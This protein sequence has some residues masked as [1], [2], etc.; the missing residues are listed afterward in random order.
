MCIR[1]ALN[2]TLSLLLA[3][4][5]CTGM[6]EEFVVTFTYERLENFC[7][8]CGMLGHITRYCNECFVDG[9]IDPVDDTPYGPWLRASPRDWVSNKAR[10]YAGSTS[11]TMRCSPGWSNHAG[12]GSFENLVR[13]RHVNEVIGEEGGSA[14]QNLG[15][16][17]VDANDFDNLPSQQFDGTIQRCPLGLASSDSLES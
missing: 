5:I 16:R 15:A 2:V 17:E 4:R 11:P 1:V 14:S 3:L 6:G 8:L 9:F 13:A 7:Y 10:S 12:G